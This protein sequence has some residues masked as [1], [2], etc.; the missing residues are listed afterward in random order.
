M[1]LDRFPLRPIAISLLCATG[2]YTLAFWTY[3]WTATTQTKAA[4]ERVR[5]RWGM[6]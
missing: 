5:A 1:R 2:L 3:D 6:S 4:E